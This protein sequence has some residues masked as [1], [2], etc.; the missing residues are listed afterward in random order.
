MDQTVTTMPI[1]IVKLSK[2]EICLAVTTPVMKSFNNTANANS[3][4]KIRA[5]KNPN[6]KES[7]TTF[8]I[9]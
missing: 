3:A 2:E 6:I 4:G 8:I 9:V 1:M 7:N 5:E